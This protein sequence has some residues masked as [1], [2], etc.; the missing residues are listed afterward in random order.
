MKVAEMTSSSGEKS[1]GNERLEE[2]LKKY[3]DQCA[4]AGVS[5]SWYESVSKSF[6]ILIRSF[7]FAIVVVVAVLFF[8]VLPESTVEYLAST[9]S[10]VWKRVL[11]SYSNRD[12]FVWGVMIAHLIPFYATTIFFGILDILRPKSLTPFKIQ[13]NVKVGLQQYLHALLVATMNQV[14][15]LGIAFLLWRILPAISPDAFSPELPSLLT[16]AVQLI[17]CLPVSEV[18][19]YSTHC[20]LHTDWF[21]NHVHYFHHQQEAPF[22][23]CCIYAHPAE[24]VIANIPVVAGGPMLMRCHMSVW[25]TWCFLATLSTAISHSGWHLPL[26]MG[27]SEGHDY[28][29]SRYEVFRVSHSLI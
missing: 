9:L 1:K 15:L 5:L 12:I 24:F 26:I 8:H 7:S 19:F 21:W 16:W 17:V 2:A 13:E 11:E 3:P 20:L 10:L 4:S 6:K 23:P 29:H 25:L 27:E 18:I 22:P 14:L 28:H